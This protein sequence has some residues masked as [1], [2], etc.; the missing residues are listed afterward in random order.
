[1]SNPFHVPPK[2]SPLDVARDIAHGGNVEDA[3]DELIGAIKEI[4]RQHDLP[5]KVFQLAT[6]ETSNNGSL[7][8]WIKTQI[9]SRFEEALK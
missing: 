6:Q 4:A 2:G 5:F 9:E 1:M 8:E 3:I 7:K